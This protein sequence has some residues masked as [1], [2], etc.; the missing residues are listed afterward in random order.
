MASAGGAGNGGGNNDGGGGNGGNAGGQ[1]QQQQQQQLPPPP[2]ED[3]IEFLQREIEQLK[4][5]IVEERFKL[6]DKSIVQVF[7]VLPF[8]M[9]LV[10]SI[11]L[12]KFFFLFLNEPGLGTGID[13]GMAM[14]P[15]PSSI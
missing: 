3:S 2:A 14:T 10:C 13:P 5:R 1:Q 4:R 15:F 7:T 6:G 11:W 9:F 8:L 12:P